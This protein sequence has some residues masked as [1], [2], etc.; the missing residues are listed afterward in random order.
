MT[1]GAP[2][3]YGFFDDVRRDDL[4]T[5]AVLHD[6]DAA[7]PRRR[8]EAGEVG[9]DQFVVHDVGEPGWNDGL[10]LVA[11]LADDQLDATAAALGQSR[12]DLIERMEKAATVKV[13]AE[14]FMQKVTPANAIDPF[15]DDIKQLVKRGYSE[16]QIADFLRA[17]DVRVSAKELTNFLGAMDENSGSGES[18]GRRG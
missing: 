2:N 12:V 4:R 5:R 14:E 15:K 8:D 3:S 10:D 11:R 16:A 6:R 18:K 9:D 13:A 7:Q 1:T 17:N